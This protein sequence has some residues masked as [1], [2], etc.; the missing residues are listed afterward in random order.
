MNQIFSTSGLLFLC[1]W[2]LQA[3]GQEASPTI[4]VTGEASRWIAADEIVI[5]ASIESVAK[6]ASQACKDSRERSQ[7]LVE[8]LKEAKIHEEQ[9]DVDLVSITPI[10][11]L[12]SS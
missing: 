12:V 7:R 9:I 10:A 2:P 11:Q 8:F 4:S 5:H 6:T 3:C 1:I